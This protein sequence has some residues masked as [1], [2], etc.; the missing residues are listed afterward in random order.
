MR[1]NAYPPQRWL[2]ILF[3]AS[4]LAVPS[5]HATALPITHRTHL[6]LDSGPRRR[7]IYAHISGGRLIDRVTTRRPLPEP[8]GRPA[9]GRAAVGWFHDFSFLVVSF[10]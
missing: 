8:F 6:D 7:S 2:L 3:L 5:Y 1:Q 4:L 10:F 9:P